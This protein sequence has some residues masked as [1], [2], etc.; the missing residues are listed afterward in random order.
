M[1]RLEK[2]KQ[3]IFSALSPPL[4]H[5]VWTKLATTYWDPIYLSSYSCTGFRFCEV[6]A[7]T[8][9]KYLQSKYLE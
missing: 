9:L 2:F 5:Y 3:K 8:M 6:E 4:P 7:Y 1:A